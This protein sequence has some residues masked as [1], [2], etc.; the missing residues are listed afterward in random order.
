MNRLNFFSCAVVLALI[1]NCDN[2]NNNPANGGQTGDDPGT[3]T[4]PAAQTK[5][6]D[7]DIAEI[8][9]TNEIDAGDVVAQ[10]NF[11]DSVGMFNDLEWHDFADSQIIST[12]AKMASVKLPTGAFAMSENF[13]LRVK[14]KTSGKTATSGRLFL[15]HI[16]LLKPAGGE[17]YK[18]GDQVPIQFKRN[19]YLKRV[20]LY[21]VVGSDETGATINDM[22]ITF[23]GTA[24][25]SQVSTYDTT[26]TVGTETGTKKYPS[27]E[28][29]IYAFSYYL[30][31]EF[32]GSFDSPGLE[33]DH[34]LTPFS[35]TQ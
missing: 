22:D 21:L 10:Y 13:Q 18:T 12:G 11:N 25:E 15:D 35:I 4:G 28:C 33:S 26:W 14:H 32:A 20:Y 1:I 2:G 9:W 27:N 8:T 3:I 16:I 31:E 34:N 30:G 29:Y 5:L 24:V 17:S 19:K 23:E 7:G 6:L